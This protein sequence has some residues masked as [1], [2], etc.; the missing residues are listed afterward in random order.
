M[1]PEPTPVCGMTPL[2]VS[3]APVTLILTT[4]G[5][6]LEATAIVADCLSML[7]GWVL[8]AVDACA[9]AGAGRGECQHRSARRKDRGQQRG[10]DERARATGT[11]L[12]F[13]GRGRRHRRVR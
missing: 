11:A 9:T 13:H 10:R 3:A 5:L 4:A 8:A 6:T 12:L 1:T 2:P 7:T